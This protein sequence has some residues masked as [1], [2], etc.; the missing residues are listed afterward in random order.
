[1]TISKIHPTMSRIQ[2]GQKRLFDLLLACLALFATC[3]LICIAWIV[4]SIDT[5]SNGFFIQRRVGRN[6]KLFNVVKIK[7]MC[8]INNID[9][10]VTQLGDPRITW[11]GSIF[12]PY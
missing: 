4:A 10:T 5:R 9:T 2:I 7:T 11:L 6:G 3:W 12:S 8:P 1:M